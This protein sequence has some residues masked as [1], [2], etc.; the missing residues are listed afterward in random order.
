MKIH[1][2]LL[3]AA[4]ALLLAAGAAIAADPYTIVG[5]AQSRTGHLVR[6]EYTVQVGAHPLDRFKMVRIVKD[7]PAAPRRGSILLLPPLGPG[8]TFYEQREHE[9]PGT[10]IAEFFA[11]RHFDVYG[12][13]L[14]FEGIP[15]GTCEAGV[16][17]C[18]IMATWNLQSMVED[19][20]FVRCADRGAP[21][22]DPHRRRRRLARRHPRVRGG[23]C[24]AR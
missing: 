16:L 5:S 9:A 19:I 22:G 21:S 1:R 10:S 23:E 3:L 14:R 11:E 2:I 13:S 24:R 7:G 17:D 18:S 6:T 8:F 12:Y 15:A 4:F 20:A